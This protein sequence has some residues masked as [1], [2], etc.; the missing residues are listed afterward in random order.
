MN[1]VFC[2][3][4]VRGSFLSLLLALAT[5][6]FVHSVIATEC[7]YD[8]A[9][10]VCFRHRNSQGQVNAFKITDTA[11]CL[12]ELRLNEKSNDKVCENNGQEGL[13]REYKDATSAE[14]CPASDQNSTYWA[15]QSCTVS[16]NAKSMGCCRTCAEQSEP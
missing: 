12:F 5:M 3:R 7:H 15:A 10:A 13:S 14:L 11:E 6:F 16:G 1:N 2:L 9:A 8:C 4:L